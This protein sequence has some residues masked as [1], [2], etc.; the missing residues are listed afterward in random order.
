M[1]PHFLSTPASTSPKKLKPL[2]VALVFFFIATRTVCAGG[3]DWKSIEPL[4]KERCYECHGGK[5][6]KGDVDLKKLDADPKVDTEFT[7]WEKVKESVEEGDMPPAK[8]KQLTADEKKALLG[9]VTQSLD[10]AMNAKAGDPGPVTMRRLTNAEYD[11]TI[12]DLTGVDFS[13]GRDFT[14]DGGGGEGFANTGDVLFMSPQSLEK[15][16]VAARKIAD[17]ATAMP[18]TG[19]RFVNHRVGIRG[20][21][22]VKAQAEQSLYVWYQKKAEPHLPKDDEDLREADYMLACWKWKHKEQ[23]GAQSLAQLA[24]DMKLHQAFLENWWTLLNNTEPKSR[25]LDLTRVPWRELPGPDA[26]KPKEVPPAVMAK[27]QQLDAER[28]I[29]Y[30]KDPKK[31]GSGHVQRQQQDADGIRPY[32]ISVGCGG[33]KEVH[34]CIGDDGDGN[35]GDIVMVNQMQVKV[36]KQ[37]IPYV[38]LMRKRVTEDKAAL[39]KLKAQPQPAATPAPEANKKDA[40]PAL[41]A[42]QL[43]K[44]IAEAEAFLAKFGK[45]PLGKQVEPDTL[46]VNAPQVIT[47]PVPDGAYDFRV[48][49][50]LDIDNP[51][52]EFATVQWKLTAGPPPD[53]TKIMPGVL[54]VWKIKTKASYQTM[55]DFEKMRIAFPDE[56]VRRL[57]E[58]ARNQYRQKPGPGVYYYS[59]EQLGAILSETDK[60]WL[61]KMKT[62]FG[63]TAP[64]A[65]LDKKRGEEFD[66]LMRE[67]LRYFA[68]MAWRR[69]LSGEENSNLDALYADGRAKELD[70]ES[71]A[72]EVIVR[73]LVSPNFLFKAETLPVLANTPATNGTADIPLNAWE[74]ASRMSYFI[75]S[76]KPDA[77]LWKAVADGSLMKPEVRA[78]QAQRMLKDQKATAL[79]KEFF[80]QW[81]DF[82]TF[83]THTGVD[84]KKFPQFTPEL[85]RDLFAESVKFFTN[86]V[87]EDRPVSE[88]TGAD[89]TFLNKRLAQHYGIPNVEGDELKLV[90]VDQFHRGG[91][92][93]MG[94]V[95]TKTSRP[96]RTSPVVRGNWLLQVVMGIT[97]PPPPP[98]VPKLKEASATPSNMREML[99]Q[100]S[101]DRACA[102]CHER[103]DPLGFALENFDP[104][105]RFR[106]QDDNGAKIDDSAEYKDGTKFAG[107]DGLRK[108]LHDRQ[109]LLDAQL[110]RKLTGYALGRQTLATDK[111][112]MKKIQDDLKAGGGKFSIAVIDLINSRQFLNRRGEQPVASN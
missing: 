2:S 17:S 11:A 5:K 20:P 99:K 80:G 35:K 43:T 12:R 10:V 73:I 50:K 74:I 97:A 84:D 19:I 21:E 30:F 81:L 3:V 26:A 70:R 94:S 100:H 63:Y 6:T 75:W 49:C 53:V 76:S 66:H 61:Q 13:L 110:S 37:T 23:T 103:I 82:N 22:Q 29:W 85:R 28:K 69:P 4:L 89:Y 38:N 109:N 112:L 72:R 15:Y 96:H 39:E 59:D 78:A 107:I 58:V 51:D 9:W 111:P 87:R 95:L 88:V 83:A 62:D 77:E 14:P 7:V 41:N 27:L 106:T 91:L 60:S 55:Q 65:N 16:L 33:Q 102:V 24:K 90:K 79:A 71:A 44:R 42:E 47:L 32:T 98:N 54:T 56:Y 40:K 92:L 64:G 1:T 57:E 36:G 52:A 8:S 18:G 108:F 46:V 34:L 25:F 31:P 104:I 101:A 48:S 105:G 86:L 68:S 93:G 67:H 45:H